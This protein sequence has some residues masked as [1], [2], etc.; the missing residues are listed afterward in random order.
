MVAELFNH[1]SLQHGQALQSRGKTGGLEEVETASLSSTGTVFWEMG[2]SFE[3][4]E[5]V[6]VAQRQCI[7]IDL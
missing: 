5:W 2:N 7:S 4:T 1:R 6:K 3:A